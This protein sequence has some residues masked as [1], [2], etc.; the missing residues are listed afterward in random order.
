MPRTRRGKSASQKDNS[1]P[2]SWNKPSN[3]ITTQQSALNTHAANVNPRPEQN[4]VHG[5]VEYRSA[6]VVT[7]DRMIVSNTRTN[8]SWLKKKSYRQQ[9]E[10]ARLLL[11]QASQNKYRPHP[12]FPPFGSCG[13]MKDS[14]GYCRV[15]KPNSNTSVSVLHGLRETK[16]KR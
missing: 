7:I 16:L 2:L 9:T 15:N 10:R 14:A 3:A 4:N 12:G 6:N 5:N 8:E 1:A 13:S 11:L